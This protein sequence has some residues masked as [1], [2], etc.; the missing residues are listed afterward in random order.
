[1]CHKQ[2]NNKKTRENEGGSAREYSFT[3]HQAPQ[4]FFTVTRELL[5]TR[6]DHHHHPFLLITIIFFTSTSSIS[7]PSPAPP[8]HHY[9]YRHHRHLRH[10]LPLIFTFS[11][12]SSSSSLS[13][14]SSPVSGRL[15]LSDTLL[16]RRHRP[17]QL[18]Q[19]EHLSS[20]VDQIIIFLCIVCTICLM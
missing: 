20:N 12:S 11:C 17:R 2:S 13:P 8:S 3:E 14:P 1:M 18:Q 19:I 10:N 5:S 15:H 9:H 6:A 7:S 16:V 4:K